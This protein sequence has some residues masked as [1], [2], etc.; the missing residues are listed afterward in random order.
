MDRQR[1]RAAQ[2]AKGRPYSPGEREAILT[3]ATDLRAAA[4]AA[5]HSCSKWTIYD[6][7][8]QQQRAARRAPRSGRFN[9]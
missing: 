3:D 1:E 2:P 6:W 9:V 8:G 7:R 4:A 5:K